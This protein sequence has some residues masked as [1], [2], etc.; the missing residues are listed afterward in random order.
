MCS[1]WSRT[2]T[3]RPDR[4]RS[5]TVEALCVFPAVAA[6]LF[7]TDRRPLHAG[8]QPME[9]PLMDLKI[10]RS[11]PPTGHGDLDLL[12][13]SSPMSDAVIDEIDGRRIRIGTSGWSTSRPATT[14]ASTS[15]RRSSTS[16][17]RAVRRWGTHPSWSRLLGSPRLYVDIED[18]LTELLGCED[19]LVLPTITHIHMSVLPVLAG[20]GWIFLDGTRA[21]DDLRRCRVAAGQGATLRRYPADDLDALERLLSD[22]PPASRSSSALDGVNSMTGNPPRPRGLARVWP[23]QYDAHAV[24]GRRPRLR[25]DRRARCR[26]A[27][28]YGIARQRPGAP[29]RARRYDN[30]VLVGGFSKAYSSLLAFL[31]LPTHVKDHLKVAAAALP[32]LRARRP[33]R[34]W[35]PCWR[36]SRSTTDAATRSGPICTTK[37]RGSWRSWT[38]SAFACRNRSG[39]PIIEL[40]LDATGRPRRSRAVP[41]RPGDLRD[42]GAYPLVPRA[43]VGFRI[44]ITAANTDDEIDE[45][46]STLRRLDER[47]GVQRREA[48]MTA[49]GDDGRGVLRND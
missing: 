42:L 35:R 4:A 7:V 47:F 20:G 23:R 49:P 16:V 29:R 17:D 46:C 18:R 34:R 1:A 13:R 15:T 36:A 30:V 38:S 2:L 45:L 26:R 40:A 10:V 27:L 19:S 32:V 8:C 44:Q 11:A 25:R 28:P 33:T 31:A 21:P 5:V 24:R 37:R 39:L 48:V 22:R 6:A 12:R 14:S 43:E 41:V 3:L 9:E